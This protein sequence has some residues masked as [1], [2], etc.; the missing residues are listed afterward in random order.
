MLFPHHVF[1]VFVVLGTDILSN[2]VFCIEIGN[3]LNDPGLRIGFRIVDRKLNFQM[4]EIGAPETLSYV[5]RFGV[6]MS[7][8]IEPGAIVETA[9]L[10]HQR[11]SF[12]MPHRVAHPVGIG[13]LRKFASIHEY[14]PVQTKRLV[15]D[16]HLIRILN[17]LARHRRCIHA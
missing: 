9:A 10:D 7:F 13:I 16:N 15:K 1:H 4:P 6:R 14:L 2:L 17:D 12:P 11:V 8:A 5:Q 3:P